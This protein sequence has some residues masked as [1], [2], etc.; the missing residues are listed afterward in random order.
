MPKKPSLPVGHVVF[1]KEGKPYFENE[2]LPD[3][4]RELEHVIACKF[5]VSMGK[6]FGRVLKTLVLRNENDNFPD[7]K[8]TEGNIEIELEIVEVV[9]RDHMKEKMPYGTPAPVNVETAPNNLIEA[10]EGKIKKGYQKSTIGKLWLLAYD[11]T[12][13][14]AGNHDK[15]AQVANSY[16]RKVNH[17]FDEIWL[18]WPTTG[19][20]PSFLESVWPTNSYTSTGKK[21]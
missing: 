5:T 9:N 3:D 15:A 13:S 1:P 11:N 10:I 18:L 6:R 8:T 12:H 16:L 2:A 17:P 20:V 14:L 19:E 7:A 21:G 4:Y